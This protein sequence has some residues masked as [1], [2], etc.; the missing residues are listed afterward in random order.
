MSSVSVDSLAQ[1]SCLDALGRNVTLPR[2]RSFLDSE[3]GWRS[4]SP[5]S[6]QTGCGERLW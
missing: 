4:P 2:L 5:S 1:G 3:C 6:I